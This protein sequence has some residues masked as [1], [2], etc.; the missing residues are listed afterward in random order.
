[1][2]NFNLATDISHASDAAL[3]DMRRIKTPCSNPA[4]K[5]IAVRILT[6]PPP[7]APKEYAKSETPKREA[8]PTIALS[9]AVKPSNSS[10]KP[11]KI[12]E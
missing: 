3:H 4:I 7:K 10:T 1:M 11:M 2:T 6:S 9:N 8:K 5:P 12:P